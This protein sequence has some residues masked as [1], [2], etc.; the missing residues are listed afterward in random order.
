[1]AM[2][3]KVGARLS[4]PDERHVLYRVRCFEYMHGQAHA[5]VPIQRQATQAS[6]AAARVAH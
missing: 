3:A 1:M 6:E 2:M 5:T 4:I